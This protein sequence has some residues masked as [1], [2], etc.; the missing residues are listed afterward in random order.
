MR[1]VTIMLLDRL[2]PFKPNEPAEEVDPAE[3]PAPVSA[4]G[5]VLWCDIAV[6]DLG[7]HVLRG[8]FH[9]HK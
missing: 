4:G 9:E 6:D 1:R 3:E 8:R 7:G 2:D 5:D